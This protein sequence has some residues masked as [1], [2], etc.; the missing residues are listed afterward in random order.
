MSIAAMVNAGIGEMQM[1]S[2]LSYLNLP[3]ISS[4]T[5]K[6]RER[7]IGSSIQAVAKQSC[8]DAVHEEIRLLRDCNR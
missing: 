8:V 4:R 7:E 2:V 6:K 5:I 3:T 1:N